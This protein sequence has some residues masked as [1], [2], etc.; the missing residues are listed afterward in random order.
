MRTMTIFEQMEEISSEYDLV[1]S[2]KY[3]YYADWLQQEANRA[4]FLHTQRHFR[5]AVENF[6]SVIAG[7]LSKMP[8]LT[9]ERMSIAENVAEEHGHNNLSKTHKET[10]LTFLDSMNEDDVKLDLDKSLPAMKFNESVRNFVLTHSYYEGAAMV[11]IIE[12]LY[13]N[14]SAL[15]AKTV[16]QRNWDE[17]CKQSHYDVHAELDVEHARELFEVSESMWNTGNEEIQKQIVNAAELG[18][19]YFVSLYNDILEEV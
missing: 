19:L 10:F 6:G 5:Y 12:H 13:I 18:A 15:I 3:N 2:E 7:V 11:G 14:M 17:F 9:E 8:I 4:D 1:N 16:H